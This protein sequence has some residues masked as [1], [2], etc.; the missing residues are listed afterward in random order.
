[1]PSS[2]SAASAKPEARLMQGW[3]ALLKEEGGLWRRAIAGEKPTC[4]AGSGTY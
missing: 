3:S 2:F 4:I 1:M